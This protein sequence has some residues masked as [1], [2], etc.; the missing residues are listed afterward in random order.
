MRSIRREQELELHRMQEEFPQ[1]YGQVMGS[2]GGGFCSGGLDEAKLL[3]SRK[4]E[5]RLKLA[6]RGRR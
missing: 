3:Q 6:M 5:L 2:N 1:A 4:A